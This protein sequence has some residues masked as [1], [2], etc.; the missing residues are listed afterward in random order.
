MGRKYAASFS[1]VA[2]TVAQDLFEIAAPSDAALRLISCHISQKTEAGDAESEQL[3]FTVKRV[4]GSP[5]SGSG[6]SSPT[7]RPL[8]PGDAAFGGTVEANNTTRI[9]GGTSVTIID[10]CANVLGDGWRYLPVEDERI[11]F[12]PSTYCIIGLENNPAD[13]VTFHGTVI[14]EEIGG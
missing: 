9:S 7:A 11:E 4:T 2:A 13:S 5:T 14:F 8:S 12:A 10:E 1:A 6:G 3:N